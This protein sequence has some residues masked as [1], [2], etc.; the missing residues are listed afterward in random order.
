[1]ERVGRGHRRGHRRH[2]RGAEVASS[3][4]RARVAVECDVGE[5]DTRRSGTTARSPARRSPRSGRGSASESPGPGKDRAAGSRAQSPSSTT[6][7]R[8]ASAIVNS[9]QK[10]GAGSVGDGVVI[11]RR[12]ARQSERTPASIE[13]Q[14]L[15]VEVAVLLVFQR[16]AHEVSVCQAMFPSCAAPTNLRLGTLVSLTPPA[17]APW[18][19]RSGWWSRPLAWR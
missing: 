18:R 15:A 1:M 5:P 4:L 14:P 11:S 19:S 7:N 3:I 13:H 2:E 12:G 17:W 16:A 8:T 6:A 10:R 9:G